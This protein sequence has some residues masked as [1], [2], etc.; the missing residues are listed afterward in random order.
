MLT[1]MENSSR[2]ELLFP[3]GMDDEEISVIDECINASERNQRRRRSRS[4]ATNARV[5]P[6]AQLPPIHL[7]SEPGEFP[8]IIFIRTGDEPPKY[9]DAIK[10]EDTAP[11]AYTPRTRQEDG[12]PP[13][14]EHNTPAVSGARQ[15]EPQSSGY[16]RRTHSLPDTSHAPSS[17]DFR[18]HTNAQILLLVEQ[19]PE[20]RNVQ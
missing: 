13:R 1:L 5:Q 4:I 10:L 12:V 7:I 8:E 6:T 9:E 3:K 15:E 18:H 2:R 19:L 20:E 11:P 14:Y 16:L 17:D